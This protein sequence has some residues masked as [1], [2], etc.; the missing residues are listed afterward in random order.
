MIIVGFDYGLRNTGVATGNTETGNATPLKIVNSRDW[1]SI[2]KIIAEWRPHFCLVGLPLNM[3]G[4]V[5]RMS[6]AAQEFAQQLAERLKQSVV[7][8]DERLSSNS[9]R[10]DLYAAGLSTR[11]KI[12]DLAA[13]RIISSWLANWR[14]NI[15]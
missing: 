10:N 8:A 14:T 7:F 15:E 1:A 2:D 6:L 9:V 12:D 5:S 11:Q 3:D 4:S 13:A